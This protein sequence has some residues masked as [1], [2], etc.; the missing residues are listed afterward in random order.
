MANRRVT[1]TRKNRDGDITAI[2]NPGQFWS[3]RAKADAIR[4]IETRMHTYYVQWPEQR[5]EIRVVNGAT[6]KYLRTDRDNT[7]RNNLDDLPDL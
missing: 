6:G 7:T 2:G 3:P 1:H 5:T 4:D